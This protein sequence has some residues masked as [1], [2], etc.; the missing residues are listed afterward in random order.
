MTHK[1]LQPFV[2]HREKQKD[3][4]GQGGIWLTLS[5][6]RCTF[7]VTQRDFSNYRNHVKSFTHTNPTNYR[8]LH[9]SKSSK[10]PKNVNLVHLTHAILRLFYLFVA[11]PPMLSKCFMMFHSWIW[12]TSIAQTH[13]LFPFLSKLGEAGRHMFLPLAI[14]LHTLD[15]QEWIRTMR[16]ES[17]CQ[18]ASPFVAKRSF[19]ILYAKWF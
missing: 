2:K 3:T 5:N 9:N 8:R 14:A 10:Q 19:Q 7:I 18:W 16:K 17:Y 13:P 11:S 12:T 6:I 4:R 15:R 1:S